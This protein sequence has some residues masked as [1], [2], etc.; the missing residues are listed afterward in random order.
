MIITT[1]RAGIS[2]LLQCQYTK[3]TNSTFHHLLPATTHLISNSL[4]HH[5]IEAATTH[6]IF[7]HHLRALHLK[8]TDP[9]ASCLKIHTPNHFKPPISPNSPTNPPRPSHRNPHTPNQ[10]I[11]AQNRTQT[12]TSRS[13]SLPLNQPLHSILAS[14]P[15]PRNFKRT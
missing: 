13:V 3:T 7:H 9:Q 1:Q 2:L 6:K 4:L 8:R 15:L 11:A 12:K 5:R 14:P 10:F